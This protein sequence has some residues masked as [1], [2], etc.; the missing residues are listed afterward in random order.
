MIS[1]DCVVG[2]QISLRVYKMRIL[3]IAFSILASSNFGFSQSDSY[4]SI[5]PRSTST[6]TGSKPQSKVWKFKD[7]FYSVFPN[8]SGTYVWK[9]AGKQWKKHLFLSAKDNSKADCYA[10]S[11]TVFILLYQGEQSEFIVL[12]FVEHGQ[13]YHFLN[14]ANDI[15]KIVFEPTTETATIA[16]DSNSRLWI[17]YEADNDIVVRN[18]TS[19]Y[20]CWSAP[21]SIFSGVADDDISGIVKMSNSVG[22]FWSNQNTQRFGF[23]YHIDGD[24]ITVWSTDEV[25]ASQS[26]LNIGNGMADDH[27]N[28]QYTSDGELFVAI[29][30]SYDTPSYS[31]I[32]LLVR[33]NHGIWD[34]L[35][36]VSDSGTR[37][38][39]ALDMSTNMVKV[40]YTSVESGGG[41]VLQESALNTIN[42]SEQIIFIEGG[43]YN[44]ASSTKFPYD[45]RSLVIASGD[46]HIVGNI[47][48]CR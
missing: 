39:V 26:A 29:K 47:V 16:V 19:P 20:T 12:K 7:A 15:A 21:L 48:E 45:C 41:I 30:T 9:L 37:P 13:Q 4:R 40:Y 3:V 31:R 25:P 17:T 2:N 42:F 22:V 43:N 5:E 34:K 1:G 32:G 27:I 8:S 38:I 36:H 6:S 11:D 18:S 33:R 14:T 24:P 10:V 23:K 44:N 46:G 28:M 35:H